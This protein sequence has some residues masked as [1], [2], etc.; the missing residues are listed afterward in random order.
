MGQ[1]Y[2]RWKIFLPIILILDFGKYG[3]TP[4]KSLCRGPGRQG[5]PTP[6]TVPFI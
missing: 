5:P 2:G 4:G 1:S 6:L 3:Q